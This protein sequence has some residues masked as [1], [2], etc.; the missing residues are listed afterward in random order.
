MTATLPIGLGFGAISAPGGWSCTTPLLGFPGAVTCTAA[1]FAAGSADFALTANAYPG[2]TAD[3]TLSLPVAVSSPTGDPDEVDLS[4]SVDTQVVVPRVTS[5]DNAT[6]TLV[7]PVV[8]TAAPSEPTPVPSP[9]TVGQPATA[10][11]VP[12]CVS[13]RRFMV[14]LSKKQGSQRGARITKAILLNARGHALKTLKSTSTAA[15]VDLRGLSRQKVT[16]RITTK[17]R[18]GKK[19]ASFTHVYETCS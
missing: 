2:I 5:L 10:M 18:H 3:M 17:P 11:V 7:T 13:H 4:T 19:T 15:D 6:A 8:G 9:A 12:G 1:S 14:H 16:V